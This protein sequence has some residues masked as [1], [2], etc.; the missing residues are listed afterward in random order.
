MV[1]SRSLTQNASCPGRA[2]RCTKPS[3]PA[4]F[5]QLSE[6]HR[7]VITLARL[8]GFSHRDIAERMGRSEDAVR[9][10]LSRARARLMVLLG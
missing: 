3:G 5:D 7:E 2:G 8:V 9:K 1:T 4:S 6:E 10:L